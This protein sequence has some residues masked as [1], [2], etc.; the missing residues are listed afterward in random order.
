MAI[1]P[2][3]PKTLTHHQYSVAEPAPF[4]LEPMPASDL[5]RLRLQKNPFQTKKTNIFTDVSNVVDPDPHGSVFKLP[6]EFGSRVKKKWKIM[7]VKF[8]KF[9]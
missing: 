5:S 4:W 8:S 7:A 9:V 3:H 1:K 6:P 2:P